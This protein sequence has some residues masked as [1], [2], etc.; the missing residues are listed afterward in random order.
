M[1]SLFGGS[2]CRPSSSIWDRSMPGFADSMMP[3]STDRWW[4]CML[5]SRSLATVGG[6]AG[7]DDILKADSGLERPL[8]GWRSPFFP[9]T[10]ILEAIESSR[11]SQLGWYADGEESRGCAAVALS[12]DSSQWQD[13]CP[14]WRSVGLC[15]LCQCC[16]THFEADSIFTTRLARFWA[17]QPS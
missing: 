15:C 9:C 10:R 17:A 1:S 4:P 2:W 6:V 3:S 11:W 5:G 16:Q 13:A 7:L 14:A 8:V 12:S